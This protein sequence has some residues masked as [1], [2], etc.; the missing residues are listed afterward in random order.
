VLIPLA[1]VPG[2]HFISLQ[3]GAGEGEARMPPT[4]LTLLPLGNDIADFAD[5]AAIVAQLDLLI[6]VDTA[7]AHLAGALGIACWVMLPDYK[8][9][10][11][12][13]TARSD[14]P[15]YPQT[16]RLFRQSRAGD[17]ATVV[18]DIR[19]ALLALPR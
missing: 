4:G 6:C 1:E 19:A 2:V 18:A 11:R 15:W 8:C 10:W 17:W 16:M 3:K 7:A 13:L 5:T 12:W 14:S 9:D